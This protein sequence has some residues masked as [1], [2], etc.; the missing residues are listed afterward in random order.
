MTMQDELEA[1]PR[2]L[3]VAA[4]AGDRAAFGRLYGRYARMVHGIALAQLRS[5]DAD[6]V[7]QDVFVRALDQLHTLRDVHA[8][9]GW[10]MAIARHLIVD[11]RRR[12][13]DQGEP[14]PEP[15]TRERQHD[16]LEAR[17]A[18]DAIRALPDAYRETVMLRLVEGM[19]GPEIA[20]RTGLTPGSVRVNLHRGMKMLRECLGNV[21]QGSGV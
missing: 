10:L 5:E 19:T 18:L 9:G 3:I 15:S 16:R 14:A 21:A 12:T 17:R 7:V 11:I 4:Q 20:E 1:D 8:F 13:P 2:E 6:D